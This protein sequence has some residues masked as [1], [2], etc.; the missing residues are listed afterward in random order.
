MS[1]K[2]QYVKKDQVCKVTFRVP[3]KAAMGAE[4]ICVVGDFNNWS[5]RD[6][7]MQKLKSGDFKT[8]IHL[9]SN[10]AYQFRYFMDERTWE[11]DWEADRYVRSDYGNCDNSVVVV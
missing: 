7:P 6:N 3:R 1:L 8:T 5:I 9:E 4:T 10:R 2:K 11:N